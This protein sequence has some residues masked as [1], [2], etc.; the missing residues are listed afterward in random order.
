MDDV[1]AD[2]TTRT[3]LG[4]RL[5]FLRVSMFQRHCSVWIRLFKRDISIHDMREVLACSFTS[6]FNYID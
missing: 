1:K 6:D 4:L 5:V 2:G 3:G